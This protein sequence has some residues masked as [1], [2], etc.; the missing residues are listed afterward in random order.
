MADKRKKLLA[1]LLHHG[2][3]SYLC[4]FAAAS[5]DRSVSVFV[6]GGGGGSCYGLVV[7]LDT[8]AIRQHLVSCVVLAGNTTCHL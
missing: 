8:V 4:V 3:Y 5:L 6:G 1:V 7:S 2:M